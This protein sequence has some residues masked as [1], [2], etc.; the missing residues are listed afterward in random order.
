MHLDEFSLFAQAWLAEG[1]SV[2]YLGRRAELTNAY[3][4]Q[5][6]AKV[7]T[8]WKEIELPEN[9]LLYAS[10][11]TLEEFQTAGKYH[12]NKVI[13]VFLGVC[14]NNDR[15]TGGEGNCAQYATRPACCKNF[16]IDSPECIKLNAQRS[17]ITLTLEFADPSK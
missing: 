1:C 10:R 11:H 6:E 8:E 3:I 14:K 16:E 13:A 17:P 9:T 2:V 4:S 7:I 5:T 12:K 15:H